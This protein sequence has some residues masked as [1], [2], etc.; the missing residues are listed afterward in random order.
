[1]AMTPH[2]SAATVAVTPALRFPHTL[3]ATGLSSPPLAGGCGGCR[4]RFRPSQR[5]RGTQGRRG[6]SHVSRVGGLL[7][8]VFGGGGRDDGEAT[9]KKYADTVARINSM[10]PEVSALSDADLRARTA[11]LQDRARSGES[12][13][14]LLPEAFAVVREASKRVLGLRPFDVQLIGGMV[15]HKGEIAEM[16]TGEGKTLVAILPAYL[17]ALSGKGV[18]VVTVNDYLARRDCEWV[19]QVP[20]FLGLQVGLIQQNM[21]PEQRREN[22]S[23]DITYVTNS[24]LGFDYLRDNLAM[25]VDELVLRN[26]NYCV[27]DEVD[28]ILIDEA[29]TPLIISGL[30][31]KPSDRYYKAAKIAEAFERD[32]HY[33]VDEKQRNVLLTEEGYADAEEI[34]DIDDLYDPREQWASYILNAIKAKELF[35]KDVNY[36]V[37][38]KEVL[39]VDEFTGRVMAGRRWS[40]GLHQA[41][42]AKEATETQE[43]ESI[44]KL[45]VTVV[46]TNKP[47]I[48]KDESDVVF[49]ATNGKWR[50]VLVEISRMNKVG[51][52]VLVG[53]TSVEQSESLSKQLREA[54]IPHEVLNAKPENVEREAEI[55]AQS[56]RLGAVTIATNMAGRGTDIILGGNAEF[57]AR[58]KLRE[59]LMPRPTHYTVH[60]ARKVMT[61]LQGSSENHWGVTLLAMR[62][63]GT[64]VGLSESEKRK[65]WEDLDGMVIAVPTNEKLFIGGDLN[66]YV[67]S[68]NVGYELAHV[69]FGY[70]SRNQ[71]GEDILDFA[72]AYNPVIANTFFRKRDSHLV[73]FTSGHR[74]SQ[75]DFVLT[76]REDKQACLDCKV[77]P[78][79]SVVPQHNLVVADL[80]F[81]IRTHRDKQ[82][83]IAR[84][85][86]WK[87]KGETSEVFKEIFFVEGAWSK[88]D[89]NNMW[90]K[91][92]TYIRKV[93]SEVLGVTKGSIGEP[94]D[95]WWWTENV[96]KAIKEKKECYRSLFHDRSA[97]NIERYK[98]AK[99]TAK[100]LVVNPIDGVIVSKKQMPPRKT[101][102][103][104]ESLFP[105]ELSKET[106]SSVKDTVEMAVKEWGDK[107]LT[108]LEAEERLSY[109]CEKGPT[110]D[111]VI[112]NLRNAFVKI[113]D[114]YK[115][116]TEEE[117][118]KVITVG[119]LHVV[120][121]ERHESRRIDNQL[122]GR[123]GR[124]GDPGS[125][126][127]FL[128]LED[129]IFRIFGGDRIQG[130][131]QAF[132]VEDLP[133]ES[134]ML[135]R[136]LDEAQRKVE[137]YFFDIRKQLF[138]YDEVLNSQ[139]DRVYAERRRALASD[140]L[141]SLIVEYAELTMDDI[142][143]ANIG[144]DTPKENWDLNKLIAKLQQYC[145]LLDDLTPE[146]L[147]GKSSSYD[148]LREY[149]RLP[150][151]DAIL[152]TPL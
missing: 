68:T 113:A 22:Y 134:K 89:A 45:K 55:V 67:G 46:P 149:L 111:E 119:G 81:W 114:E 10:E 47:M 146:L 79:E 82:A 141:Q 35:L 65:F 144:P 51:R 93:A 59:I 102:K 80:R 110:R 128:S 27:I 14:S 6:G 118:Q 130:L 122:R 100:Q 3:S 17:N 34:L 41:I 70:G 99:K 95:T 38:S 145:H 152:S 54:G 115:V 30:A 91:I 124:Q 75:I 135:T 26:F 88:E 16:K 116:Y 78:G 64:R 104:N 120:G 103:T 143:G 83:K 77:L 48:R 9:R 1:M 129:N 151:L 39:I 92:T 58:L 94:K 74:S 31:E 52:P 133:I 131:M 66:G 50:A 112:A 62:H 127:F 98:V 8:T 109:S 85:K 24:E 69:G 63:I 132:R 44:Y 60:T 23:Y 56:G 121:T 36:I 73:T 29:R 71:E 42:E 4:V 33:T 90:V 140:S 96:Q 150:V 123:S 20:R 28:S 86:W 61:E 106:L 107:S 117:K 142:L 148:D 97:I 137:N 37:R 11:A 32:I 138:E 108:E 13:D 105:C 147:E 72:I 76:R 15:L 21:T 18:H 40:D 53:T 7:G 139:R 12:L 87:L 125:S 136:A 101:W 25:T 43:F 126:R 84:T 49:R 5:G 2:A 57:M 19:G